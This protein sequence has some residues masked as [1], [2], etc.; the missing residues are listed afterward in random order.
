MTTSISRLGATDAQ[1]L[2][3]LNQLFGTIF[4]DAGSYSDY[5][6]SDN[7][8]K[9]FLADEKHI[10]LIAEAENEIA[11]GLVAYALSKFERERTEVYLYDVAVANHMQRHGIGRQLISELRAVAKSIGA[12]VVFVQADED[13]EAVSFYESLGPTENLRTRSFDFDT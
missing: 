12:Y 5:K 2:K 10:V 7:Y 13:D 3:A 11:G 4:E 9:N 8:L 6:P 1:R